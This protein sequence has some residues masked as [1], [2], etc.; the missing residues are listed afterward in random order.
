MTDTIGQAQHAMAPM[1][2]AAWWNIKPRGTRKARSEMKFQS[3]VLFHG[4]KF[5]PW[6][7]LIK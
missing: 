1:R 5:I 4:Y 7:N 2:L 3:L 6:T